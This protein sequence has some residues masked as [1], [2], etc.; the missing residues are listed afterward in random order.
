MLKQIL[1]IVIILLVSFSAVSNAQGRMGFV[2]KIFDK[3]EANILFGEVKSS[4][5]LKP[6]VLKQA[7]L[8]AK[9]YV[10]FV[11]KNGR[12]SIVNEKKQV[13]AGEVQTVTAN[14][15]MHIFSKD[16]VAEFVSLI[17][18]S[19]IAVEDRGTTTTLTAGAYTLE[20]STQCPPM[21]FE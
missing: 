9:D 6:N 3:N 5:E 7:L 14:E 13:L 4:V 1:G 18:S 20:F 10:V 12:I 17:G 15:T 19:S 16:K 11:V 8:K 21:C 2:G